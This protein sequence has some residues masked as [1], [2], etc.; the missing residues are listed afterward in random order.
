V[1]QLLET[2]CGFEMGEEN[3]KKGNISKCEVLIQDLMAQPRYQQ[4]I[5]Q[6][7]GTNLLIKCH[8]CSDSGTEGKARGYLEINPLQITLCVNRIQS[9]KD[10]YEKILKH[11]LTH[12][13]DYLTKNSDLT[14]CSGLAYSEVRAA[15][16]GECSDYFIH[17]YFR[18]ECIRKHAI[19]STAV[20]VSSF[21]PL[22]LPEYLSIRS[23]G[24]C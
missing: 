5:Q 24:L 20:R 4:L 23:K 14:T 18:N 10:S 12:A 17:S 3:A 13:Y 22:T 21:F 11:E 2:M 15:R 9:S 1:Y 7:N 6:L 19:R 16:N 8:H